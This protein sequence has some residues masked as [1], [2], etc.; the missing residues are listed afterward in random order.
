MKVDFR[1]TREGLKVTFTDASKE[2]PA[3]HI[4]GTSVLKVVPVLK[5]TQ[6]TPILKK[7]SI[8]LL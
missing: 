6:N 5:E 1:F 8:M 2:V 7:V 4:S 3:V